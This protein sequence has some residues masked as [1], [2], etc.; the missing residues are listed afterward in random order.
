MRYV[1]SNFGLMARENLNR[2]M[3][4]KWIIIAVGVV[5]A[6]LVA[7]G[8][9]VP[10][11]VEDRVEEE[12][13][14]RLVKRGL[15]AD[16]TDFSSQF[17]RTFRIEGLHLKDEKRGVVA[18]ADAVDI[19]IA[20]DSF[21]D[22]DVRLS[23]V[24]VENFGLEVDLKKLNQKSDGDDPDSPTQGSGLIQKILENPPEIFMNQATLEVSHGALSLAQMKVEQTQVELSR[25][26]VTL[27]STAHYKTLFPVPEFLSAPVDVKVKATLGLET[28][29]FEFELTHPEAEKPLMRFRDSEAGSVTVGRIAGHGNLS[30]R[31]ASVDAQT[32]KVRIGH[33]SNKAELVA[34][35]DID[36]LRIQRDKRGRI[37][38]SLNSPEIVV[39]PANAARLRPLLKVIGDTR[40]MMGDKGEG[41]K[42]GPRTSKLQTLDRIGRTFAR[43]LHRQDVQLRDLRFALNVEGD[44][45]PGVFHQI[46]LLERINIKTDNGTIRASGESADGTVNALVDFLPGVAIPRFAYVD[47]SKVK[48]GKIPGMP[49]GRTEL[50]SRGTSGR[51]D[52][53]FSSTF[54]MRGPGLGSMDD[55][56]DVFHGELN[57]IWEDGEADFVGVSEEP[58]TGINLRTN[59]EFIWHPSRASFEAKNGFFKL[60]PIRVNYSGAI[61]GFPLDTTLS[62]EAAMEELEC[63]RTFRNLPAAM[64]GPYRYIKMDGKWAP[65]FSFYLPVNRPRAVNFEIEGYEDVCDVLSL[66]VQRGDWPDIRLPGVTGQERS[67]AL[68]DVFWLEKPFIK[69]VT[70]GLATDESEVFVGPGLP[71]YVPLSEMPSWVGGAAY[72]S[73]EILFYTD[74]G[75]SL[76]LIKKA[77]RLNLEKGRFVYG[78]S[79][80]TQQL[81]KNLFLTRNKTL[82]RK[83]QEA[84]I[85]WRITETIPKDRVLELYLNVIEF[86]PDIYGIGPAARYYFQKD[87][88]DLTPMESI[89]LAML[90]PSP[91]YGERVMQRGQ[92]PKGVWWTNRTVEL[93]RR[94][95]EHKHLTQEQAEAAKPYELEWEKGVYK[96]RTIEVPLFD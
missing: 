62:G 63:D 58:L 39:T 29:D 67:D 88:R 61:S 26:S 89:F 75:I 24:N 52:G 21:T 18:R 93:F 40:Q 1:Y 72:L 34:T 76:G 20:I 50:P 60:G 9:M 82:S 44:Y 64:L 66:N 16:W 54:M 94:L 15:E 49:K 79:T 2:I 28:R 7:G 36:A 86:G 70:E 45:T 14:A 32:I 13:R 56:L 80:V 23:A 5:L 38:L 22:A 68:S 43:V 85:A 6:L 25:E 48:L 8:L 27:D 33:A 69:Q 4:K 59:F 81:I 12:L 41:Q 71:T 47:V 87:A 77:L 90:K 91:L 92:T 37:S 51:V 3:R 10:N 78:G 35:T 55:L 96:P 83:L 53:V 46:T 57:V 19:S 65:T 31:T 84:L 11:L 95:V 30:D 73:E 17:G 42:S 74:H